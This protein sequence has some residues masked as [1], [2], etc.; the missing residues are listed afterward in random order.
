MLHFL[1]AHVRRPTTSTASAV[2]ARAYV[3]WTR[4]CWSSPGPRV[5]ANHPRP[6]K[7]SYGRT[8]AGPSPGCLHR[9]ALMDAAPGAMSAPWPPL[10]EPPGMASQR[11]SC[12]CGL[13]FRACLSGSPD[14]DTAGQHQARHR[15]ASSRSERSVRA[16][17]GRPSAWPSFSGV[18]ALSPLPRGGPTQRREAGASPLFHRGETEAHNTASGHKAKKPRGCYGDSLFL[19]PRSCVLNMGE[20]AWPAEKPGGQSVSNK[21]PGVSVMFPRL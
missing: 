6:A 17:C 9:D 5:A 16:S 18:G 1:G 13:H 2:A 14:A 7:Q 21:A 19:M 8:P 20:S 12:P 11:H 10:Q 15:H 3:G 4:M